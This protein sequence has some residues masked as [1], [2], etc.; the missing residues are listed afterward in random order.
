MGDWFYVGHGVMP[1]GFCQ[2]SKSFFIQC[3]LDLYVLTA[4]E[5]RVWNMAQTLYVP[6]PHPRYIFYSLQSAGSKC[7]RAGIDGTFLLKALKKERAS[8]RALPLTY[9]CHTLFMRHFTK[10]KARYT[11]PLGGT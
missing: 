9:M 3:V 5:T 1:V 8:E 2:K 4:A 7:C 11:F 10:R 6:P